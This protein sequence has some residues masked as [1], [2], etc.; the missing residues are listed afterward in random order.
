MC[1]CLP[2][3][4][5]GVLRSHIYSCFYL[6]LKLLGGC[7]LGASD[8]CTFLSTREFTVALTVSRGHTSWLRSACCRIVSLRFRFF[9]SKM[10]CNTFTLFTS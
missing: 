6:R 9:M 3:K 2:Y 4:S 5:L 8:L 7:Q 1:V 10:E